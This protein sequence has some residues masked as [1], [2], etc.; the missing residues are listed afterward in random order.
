MRHTS[1]TRLL[2]SS[3]LLTNAKTQF[4]NSIF[5][6]DLAEELTGSSDNLKTNGVKLFVTRWF[7]LALAT[8][9]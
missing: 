5:G 3:P 9:V 8:V 1:W 4:S 6:V 7:P 2:G